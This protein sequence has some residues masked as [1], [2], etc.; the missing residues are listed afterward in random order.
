MIMASSR[1]PR[2]ATLDN[3]S[4]RPSSQRDMMAG[5]LLPLLYLPQHLVQDAFVDA[6]FL[7]MQHGV[8][9][10][11]DIAA[12]SADGAADAAGDLGD[13]QLARILR[14]LAVGHIRQGVCDLAMLQ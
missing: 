3:R 7:E 8:P 13:L 11:F 4:F 5:M 9:E 12:G 1:G 2:P 6:H 14:M 10:I